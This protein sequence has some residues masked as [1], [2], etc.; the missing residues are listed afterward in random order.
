LFPKSPYYDYCDSTTT[1]ED[2]GAKMSNAHKAPRPAATWDRQPQAPLQIVIP[3]E[4]EADLQQGV[5]RVIAQVV[6]PARPDAIVVLQRA[7]ELAFEAVEGC[8]HAHDI[9]LPRRIKVYLGKQLAERAPL[10]R[11]PTLHEAFFSP[12]PQ[13][14]TYAAYCDYAAWLV[15]QPE[16]QTIVEQLQAQAPT[17]ADRSSARVLI[18]DDTAYTGVTLEVAARILVQQAYG[19][20]TAISTVVLNDQNAGWL[21]GGSMPTG[22]M[23]AGEWMPTGKSEIPGIMSANWPIWDDLF[24]TVRES[25]A[26]ASFYEA[27]SRFMHALLFGYDYGYDASD[28]LVLV[29]VASENEIEELSEVYAEEFGLPAFLSDFCRVVNIRREQLA[30]IHPQTVTR[31]RALGAGTHL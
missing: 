30:G 11:F 8:A 27:A 1:R 6:A 31:L 18:V 26:Q 10:E 21:E 3:T 29:P 13:D 14:E 4:V 5:G 17:V 20:A 24:E 19:A 15:Q 25:E 7:G 23:I 12:D 9:V 22:R 2:T 16:A 28:R